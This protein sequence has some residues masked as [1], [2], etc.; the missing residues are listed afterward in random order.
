MPIINV[1]FS[2]IGMDVVRALPRSSA[3]YQY[4]LVFIEY[5]MRYPNAEPLWAL[6]V[7]HISEE[8][9]KWIA[10]MGIPQEIL[11]DQGWNFMSRVLRVVC[12]TLCI[13][14]L[15]TSVYHPQ[16]NSL[17]KHLNGT[18]KKNVAAL[19]MGRPMEV[20]SAPS[21]STACT[22]GYSAGFNKVFSLR[23]STRTPLERPASGT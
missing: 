7:P 14:Q 6:M 22:L 9:I 20:G 5:T 12:C 3:G 23:T 10:R 8:L 1:P 15:R 4:I 13:K 21:A 2:R 11:M 17:V 18:I 19:Y 16:S